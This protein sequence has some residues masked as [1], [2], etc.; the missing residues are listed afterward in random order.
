MKLPTEPHRRALWQY[1][2]AVGTVLFCGLAYC[3]FVT[4][5][6]VYLPCLFSVFTHLYCPGCG[7]TRAL[8]ALLRLDLVG[9]LTANP[10][11]AVTALILLW[12]ELCFLR[13]AHRQSGRVSAI[14][15]Y[16]GCAFFIGWGILRNLL[17]VRLGID[18]LGDLLVFWS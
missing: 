6:R 15:L 3:L 7:C 11:V 5:T 8:R 13:N 4:L 18:P 16:I 17:L 9:S 2:I 12:Y 10:S 1:H 14:P